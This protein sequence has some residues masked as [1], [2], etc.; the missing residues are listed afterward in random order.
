[1]TLGPRVGWIIEQG[2]K[3]N[4]VR[5]LRDHLSDLF[6]VQHRETESPNWDLDA[7]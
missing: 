7:L 5:V 2:E 4:P 6:V 3:W 1:M